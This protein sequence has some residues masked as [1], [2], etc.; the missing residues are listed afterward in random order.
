MELNTLLHLVPRLKTGAATCLL[1]SMTSGCGN[2]LLYLTAFLHRYVPV[3]PRKLRYKCFPADSDQAEG[4]TCRRCSGYRRCLLP[5]SFFSTNLTLSTLQ[6]RRDS[7]ADCCHLLTTA[8]ASVTSSLWTWHFLSIALVI[9]K[10]NVVSP[11]TASHCQDSQL[12]V[13]ISFQKY[14]N[15]LPI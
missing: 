7:A 6:Y 2:G 8:V 11:H 12:P 9:I 3:K 10:I 4:Q 5:F 13:S 15:I 1:Q 14:L